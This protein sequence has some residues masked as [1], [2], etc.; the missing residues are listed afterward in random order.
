MAHT[1]TVPG[2]WFSY[3][4]VLG[5]LILYAKVRDTWI[6]CAKVLGSWFWYAKALGT[7]SLDSADIVLYSTCEWQFLVRTLLDLRVAVLG[8]YLYLQKMYL[9]AALINFNS[10]ESEISASWKKAYLIKFTK[11]ENIFYYCNETST[12]PFRIQLAIGRIL[13]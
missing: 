13:Q 9:N 7:W 6:S 5:A 12:W 8:T 10:A 3:T 2:T 4:K 1:C 11:L